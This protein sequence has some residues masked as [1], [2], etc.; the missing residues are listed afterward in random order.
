[1]LK[2]SQKHTFVITDDKDILV[3]IIQLE[4]YLDTFVKE[5]LEKRYPDNHEKLTYQLVTDTE[6]FNSYKSNQYLL[7]TIETQEHYAKLLLSSTD[8][9]TSDKYDTTILL[10]YLDGLTPSELSGIIADSTINLF[11]MFT[12][13][14]LGGRNTS[15]VWQTVIGVLSDIGEELQKDL[16]VLRHENISAEDKKTC[17]YDLLSYFRIVSGLYDVIKEHA[18]YNADFLDFILITEPYLEKIKT[19]TLDRP[20]K[21]SQ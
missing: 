13:M 19:A 5:Y 14:F 17:V 11:K 21:I 9:D 10:D 12:N 7:R 2:R 15:V 18:I 20:E 16:R 6:L 3:D 4:G 1:M 8:I